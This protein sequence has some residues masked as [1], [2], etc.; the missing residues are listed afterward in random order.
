[1]TRALRC[2]RPSPPALR[3]RTDFEAHRQA[4]KRAQSLVADA[5]AKVSVAGEALEAARTGHAEALAQ[6][7]STGQ[8]PKPNGALRNARL[9]LADAEDEAEAART[10]F[11][12]LKAD[13][14]DNQAAQADNAVLVEVAHVLALTGGELLAR[15]QRTKAESLILKET[16]YA[17]TSE[18]TVGVPLFGGEIQR[19]N[20]ADARRAPL[21]ELRD[22]VLKRNFEPRPEELAA[23]REAVKPF[24]QWRSTLR[25]DGDAP[26]PE[27]PETCHRFASG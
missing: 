9:A 1:M 6:A 5:E 24:V 16:L 25:R 7:A 20:A 27:G 13:P 2:A 26:M 23:A 3:P 12:Q 15:A 8:S 4:I 19:L 14:G 10:A 11:E 17:L 21:A 18:E 22:E